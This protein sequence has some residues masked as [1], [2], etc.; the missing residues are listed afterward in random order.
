MKNYHKPH[1]FTEHQFQIIAPY[2][3]QARQRLIRYPLI[4]ELKKEEDPQVVD[5]VWRNLLEP[6]FAP[7]AT[8]EEEKIMILAD[9][10]ASYL[11]FDE[12]ISD[13]IDDTLIPG[14]LAEIEE[15]YQV[16]KDTKGWSG[17]KSHEENRKAVALDWFKIHHHRL[18]YLKESHLKDP[19]LYEDGGGQE[20]RNFRVRLLKD[21]IN[22]KTRRKETSRD[23]IRR[24][25]KAKKPKQLFGG[26][27]FGGLFDV[28]KQAN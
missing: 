15:A 26:G 8:P 4:F 22:D 11:Y 9:M 14:A 17:R 13:W 10:A 28:L 27:L 12:V 2:L 25:N 16:I 6:Y 3:E 19:Q 21:I 24:L 20:R 5:I 23:I 1:F 7:P 18:A